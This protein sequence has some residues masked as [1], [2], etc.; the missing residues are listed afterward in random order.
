M[1]IFQVDDVVAARGRVDA[2]GIRRVWNADFETISSSHLHPADVGAAI[3][4]IDEARPASSWTWGGPGWEQRS[5]PGKLT[6]AVL[7]APDPASL[8]SKWGAALGAEVQGA[9][10]PLD[11]GQL[12]FV[13][14]DTERLSSFCI[15][16]TSVEDVLA[17]AR[18]QGLSVGHDSI[19]FHGVHLHLT[20][21]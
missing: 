4:S 15:A 20:R 7:S 13:P 18:Q 14:G 5:R 1:A 3:V 16:V 9:T 19:H 6:G 17:R 2:L 21:R 10:I 12:A 8:A 11:D